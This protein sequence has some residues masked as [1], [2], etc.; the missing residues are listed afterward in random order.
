[1]PQ[2][3]RSQLPA[4]VQEKMLKSRFFLCARAGDHGPAVLLAAGRRL[5]VR[6]RDAVLLAD[7]GAAVQ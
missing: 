5:V 6:G 2:F 4:Y 7:W 3:R 1:M